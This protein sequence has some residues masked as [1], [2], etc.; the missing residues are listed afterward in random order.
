MTTCLATLTLEVYY[1]YIPLYKFGQEE[2]RVGE[3]TLHE[4]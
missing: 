3:S 4:S 1:R 2:G